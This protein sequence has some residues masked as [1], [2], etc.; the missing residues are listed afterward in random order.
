ML[1]PDTVEM[2]M[3]I[4]TTYVVVRLARSRD[5]TWT[6]LASATSGGNV[7]V[8]GNVTAQRLQCM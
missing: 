8:I 3:L 7:G 1:T 6:G 4:D 2:N 5:S